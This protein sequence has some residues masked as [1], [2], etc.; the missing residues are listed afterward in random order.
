MK[1]G[2]MAAVLREAAVDT[3]RIEIMGGDWEHGAPFY[4]HGPLSISYCFA[5]R[6]GDNEGFA[7]WR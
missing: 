6:E 5:L 3:Q 2:E 4:R 1:Q 7:L